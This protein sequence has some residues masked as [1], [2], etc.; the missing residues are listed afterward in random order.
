M[1]FKEAFEKKY[2]NKRIINKFTGFDAKKIDLTEDNLKKSQIF[3]DYLYTTISYKNKDIFEHLKKLEQ[4]K[5]QT[6]EQ[7]NRKRVGFKRRD[8]G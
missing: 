5:H 7:Q 1:K 4:V 2:E 6:L 3:W 8:E